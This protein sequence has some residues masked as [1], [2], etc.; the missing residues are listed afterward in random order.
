MSQDF[1]S[2]RYTCVGGSVEQQA[3][4]PAAASA[5]FASAGKQRRHWRKVNGPLDRA[6]FLLTGSRGGDLG[7]MRGL[8]TQRGGIRRWRHVGGGAI[9]CRRVGVETICVGAEIV[10]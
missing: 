8:L 6:R 2:G 9:K 1:T 5:A 7:V 10:D 3:A 4:A